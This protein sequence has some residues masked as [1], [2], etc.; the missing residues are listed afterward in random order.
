LRI[1]SGAR[2]NLRVAGA[3]RGYGTVALN[4]PRVG[5]DDV[6]ID[7][8]GGIAIEGA[9]SITVNAFLSDDSAR[10]GTDAA[11]DGGSYQIIDQD[12]LDRLHGQ[13]T[14]FIHAAL[15]N[16]DLMDHRLAGLRDYRDQFHLRPGVQIVS[17]TDPAINPDGNLHVDGDLDLSGYRYASVNPHSRQTG[18]RGSGEAGALVIRARG[19]LEVFGSISDG[20]DG[21][22]LTPGFDDQGWILTRGRQPHGADVVVPHGGM[23]TLIAGTVFP[24]GKVLN[25]DVRIAGMEV[26][27]G[28]RLPADVTLAQPMTLA[29]GTVLGAPVFDAGGNLLYAAGTVLAD[30][31]VLPADTRLGAGLRL[32]VAAWAQDMIWPAGV[33]LPAPSRGSGVTLAADVILAK[34]AFI[35]SE[36]DVKLPGDVQLVDLRDKDADGYQGRQWTLAP[37][38]AAGSQ[39]WDITLVGGADPEAAD[40]LAV[41]RERTGGLRL[42]DN[43]YGMG[44]QELPVPGTGSPAVYRWGDTLNPEFVDLV[45]MFGYS[46]PITAGAVIT[47]AEVEELKLLGIIG[48]D[49]GELNLWGYGDLAALVTPAT[50]PDMEYYTLPVREQLASVVRTGNV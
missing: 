21:S 33:A 44:M 20:F 16:A 3:D 50:P 14:A 35:P 48:V 27:A 8:R 5:G 31:V 22:R 11:T 6:A 17:S 37:M 19:D 12:Y 15:D 25:Y 23:V 42:S 26:A 40:R 18:A 1:D 43:H 13:N 2:M 7:A 46:F 28:T 24:S 39:S 45:S 32:P 30:A 10:P 47:P 41:T 29:R 36:T 9:K 4:A 49:A 34:G 38:L